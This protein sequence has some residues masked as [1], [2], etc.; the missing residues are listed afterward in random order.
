MLLGVVHQND[1][2]LDPTEIEQIQELS[3]PRNKVSGVEH[4]MEIFSL[5]LASLKYLQGPTKEVGLV[6]FGV[7][8]RHPINLEAAYV[9]SSMI[10]AIK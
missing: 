9:T 1:G 8:T 10:S 4:L 5:L 3:H 6:Q 7:L 2:I